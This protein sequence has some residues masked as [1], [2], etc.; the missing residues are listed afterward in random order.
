MRDVAIVGA[1]QSTYGEHPNSGIKEL[2]ATAYDAMA[3]SVDRGYDPDEVDAAHVGSLGVGGSQ[4]GI[5]G[6]SLTSHVGLTGLPV[7]RV[8]NACASGGFALLNAVQAVGSGIHDAVIASGVEKM[9]DLSG[10][11]S[12]YWLGVSGDTE[13]ERLAGMTFAGVYAIVAQRYLAETDAE[14]DHLSK[15]AVKNHE[16]GALNPKAQFQREVSVEKAAGAPEIADPL[17]LYDACP[18]TDGA[19]CALVVPADEAHRYTD[20]PVYITGF[21]GGS[22]YLALHDR[23][24]I[25]SLSAVR[26]AADAAYDRAGR[27]PAEVDFAEVHD[28]FTIAELLAYEDLGFADRGEGWRLVEEGRTARDGDLPVNT[29]GGLKAKGHPLGATGIGQVVEVFEQ[30]RGEAGDRQ[31]DGEVALSHNVGGSGGAATVFV[32]E[33]AR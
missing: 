4:L 16:N 8:E 6:A 10:D 24:T 33:V 25:T 1:G 9:L 29:S 20:D 5:T 28:C 11:R 31:V 23:E 19:A 30:L 12:K 7:Q 3:E 14:H 18:T 15:V 26:E 32:Y 2:F 17:N 22:D 13:Y 27:T 21:G